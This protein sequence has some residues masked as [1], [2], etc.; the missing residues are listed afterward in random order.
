MLLNLIIEPRE[1]SEVKVA[2]ALPV[3]ILLSAATAALPVPVVKSEF[4]T[5][6]LQYCTFREVSSLNSITFNAF[7]LESSMTNSVSP[8][9]IFELIQSTAVTVLLYKVVGSPAGARTTLSFSKSKLK[10]ASSCSFVLVVPPIGKPKLLRGILS[11]N[12]SSTSICAV[13][14]LDL[15]PIVSRVVTEII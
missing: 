5:I 1:Y 12:I 2:D 6:S 15:F 9:V 8:S 7:A 3:T 10:L 13:V 4:A 11:L 14:G